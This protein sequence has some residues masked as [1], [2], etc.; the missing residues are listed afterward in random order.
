[1]PNSERRSDRITAGEIQ[2]PLGATSGKI[3]PDLEVIRKKPIENT[4]GKNRGEIMS[5]TKFPSVTVAGKEREL[6]VRNDPPDIRDRIYEP[7]L[8]QLQ[9]AIDHRDPALVLDQEQEGACTGFGLAAVINLLNEKRNRGGF[10]AST[11]MLYEM[12]KKHDEWP[13]ED[14]AGSSCRG[15]IRGWK[16]MGVCPDGDPKNAAKNPHE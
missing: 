12:A 16:N 4:V 11:R 15:A 14:Y 5:N 6:N 8:I 13:G 3:S 9:R 1:M 7:A 2:L 10:R